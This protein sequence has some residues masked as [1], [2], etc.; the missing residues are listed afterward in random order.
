MS[1]WYDVYCIDCKESCGLYECYDTTARQIL[2]A[3]DTLARAAAL[4]TLPENG[5]L[6]V[7]I[8]SQRLDGQG[9]AF[10]GKHQ[11]HALA[12]IT[13]YGV[14]EDECGEH[15]TCAHCA[16]WI[17]C[18]RTKGHEGAHASARD[19]NAIK[20]KENPTP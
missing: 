1:N 6:E 3:K 14:V 10:F 5:W 9:L 17:R 12:L 19:A 15:W 2:D 11:H 8:Y 13:E 7:K 20:S 16:S 18:H 4:A